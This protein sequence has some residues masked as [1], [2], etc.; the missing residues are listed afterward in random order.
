M[1]KKPKFKPEIT[2]IKLNPEQAVLTC[3]CWQFGSAFAVSW[4]ATSPAEGTLCTWGV[5]KGETTGRECK[6]AGS[7]DGYRRTDSSG[8]S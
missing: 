3:I 7:A 4:H 5:P 6:T 1:S 2:R 8:S